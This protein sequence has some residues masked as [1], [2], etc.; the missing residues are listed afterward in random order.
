MAPSDSSAM[1][2]VGLRVPTPLAVKGFLIEAPIHQKWG[3]GGGGGGGN[4]S[5]GCAQGS[6]SRRKQVDR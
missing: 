2:Q 3:G 5:Y 1:V 4:Q 6:R